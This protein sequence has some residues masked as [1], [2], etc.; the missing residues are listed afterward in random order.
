PGSLTGD[1]IQKTKVWLDTDLSGGSVKAQCGPWRRA[2]ASSVLLPFAD[3]AL[4]I[5]LLRWREVHELEADQKAIGLRRLRHRRY[6][7]HDHRDRRG[8]LF[9]RELCRANRFEG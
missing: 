6:V 7:P 9:E 2:Q 8:P 5:D 1:R 4:Q 3:Q